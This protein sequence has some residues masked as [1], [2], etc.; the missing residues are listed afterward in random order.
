MSVK[1]IYLSGPITGLNYG[2][3]TNWRDYAKEQLEAICPARRVDVF[4]PMRSKD[5]L[6][7]F[8]NLAGRGD[9]YAHLHQLSSKRGIW[10]RDSMDTANADLLLVNLLGAKIVSIGT[11]FEVAWACSPF[12]PRKIPIV[13]VM[14]DEGNIHEHWF[15][16]M[17]TDFRVNNLAAGIHL[18]RQ[19]LFP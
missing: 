4:S 13:V 14:E 7:K 15:V 12:A 9:D 11:M 3:A 10:A 18:S 8:D 16:E 5:Y 6:A 1:N 17:A 2:E 19:I